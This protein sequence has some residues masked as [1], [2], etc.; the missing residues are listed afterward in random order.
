MI[1]AHDEAAVAAFPQLRVLIELRNAGWTLRPVVDDHHEVTVVQGVRVY[2]QG[3][4][5]AIGVRYTTDAQ[6][7]RCDPDGHVVW[8]RTGTLVEVFDALRELPTAGG[9]R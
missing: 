6:A 3:W 1:G 7:L 4:V 9:R 2:P 8:K 5:D